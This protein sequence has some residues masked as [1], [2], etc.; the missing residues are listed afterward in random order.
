MVKKYAIY[1]TYNNQM[2]IYQKELHGPLF[3]I[4]SDKTWHMC[5]KSLNYQL[6]ITLLLVNKMI[7]VISSC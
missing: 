7:D 1:I 3:C 5:N 6:S 4:I 2:D